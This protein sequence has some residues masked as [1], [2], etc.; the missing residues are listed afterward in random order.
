MQDKLTTLPCLGKTNCQSEI[1]HFLILLIYYF[2]FLISQQSI[3]WNLLFQ[4]LD[5]WL[6]GLP[7]D[8]TV[9]KFAD[10]VKVWTL[11]GYLDVGVW[12]HLQN[13]VTS[14]VLPSYSEMSHMRRSSRLSSSESPPALLATPSGRIPGPEG[15][16]NL[17]ILEQILS[18]FIPSQ[19]STI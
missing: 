1:L 16:Q 17:G 14:D 19:C 4:I 2:R 6:Q 12:K 18:N 9:K 3:D 11:K 5:L 8:F 7:S 13:Y 10:E 15:K